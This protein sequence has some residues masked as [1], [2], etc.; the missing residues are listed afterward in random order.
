MIQQTPSQKLTVVIVSDAVATAQPVCD[1]LAGAGYRLITTDSEQDIA[2]LAVSEAADTIVIALPERGAAELHQ[3][4]CQLK[5]SL[6]A[7]SVPLFLVRAAAADFAASP[8]HDE[9]RDFTAQSGADDFL[10]ALCDREEI[11]VKVARLTERHRVE[12]F[13][14]G[15]YNVWA[16]SSEE[17]IDI[18]GAALDQYRLLFE[19]SPLPMWVYDLETLGFLAVNQAAVRHYGYTRD[20]FLRMT[21]KDIRPAEDVTAL[22]SRISQLEPGLDLTGI[23]RHCQ[24]QGSVIDVEITSHEL[25]FDGRRARLVLANDVTERRRAEAALAQQAEREALSTAFQAPCA[26]RSTRPKF[27]APRSMNSECIWASTVVCFFR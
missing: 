11:L 14:R 4:C 13:Y 27:F 18:S 1:V 10:S 6:G 2:R 26:A 21:I 25:M 20:E 19:S 16:A 9:N 24:K 7:A 17:A 12:Q 15:T 22:L 5:R 3:F 8:A 23:W